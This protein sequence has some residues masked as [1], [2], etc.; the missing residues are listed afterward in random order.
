MRGMDRDANLSVIEIAEKYLG[1]G[2]CAIDLAGDECKYPVSDYKELF[3]EA[4]KRNIPFTIH[5]GESG[6]ASEVRKAIEMGTVRIGHGVHAIEDESVL[7]L[8][9]EKNVLLE[10]CPTS[11]IQT[12]VAEEYKDH[13][14]YELYSKGIKLCINTDN[15]TVS[16]VSI[17][18][19]YVKLY[20]NFNFSMDD[21]MLMNKNAIDRAFISQ[22][23]KELLLKELGD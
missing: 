20:E 18:D 1:K 9:K 5:A 21:F 7:D 6:S 16:N 8:I 13:P 17:S 14:V 3:E 10:V 11:N 12:D 22:E 23:E 19:E 4:K 2:V 15:A